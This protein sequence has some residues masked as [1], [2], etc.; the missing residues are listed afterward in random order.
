MNKF[1]Q[2]IHLLF[3]GS[4]PF[5]LVYGI[6]SEDKTIDI[7]IHDTIFIIAIIHVMVLLSIIFFL[8][9]LIYYGLYRN[10]NCKPLNNI[11]FL[12][13][14]LTFIG[15]TILFVLPLYQKNLLPFKNYED[16]KFYLGMSRLYKQMV[17]F[18]FI[19]IFMGQIMFILNLI[20]SFSKK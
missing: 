17:A 13:V 14:L 5:F 6:Q 1:L 15:I 20:L 16:Y 18:G 7:N 3:W 19:A 11:T 2:N 10:R 12:H 9:G 4:I 8:I